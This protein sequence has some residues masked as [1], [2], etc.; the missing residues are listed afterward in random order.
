MELLGRVAATALRHCNEPWYSNPDHLDPV[1]RHLS[2]G[3]ARMVFRPTDQQPAGNHENAADYSCLQSS[4]ERDSEEPSRHQGDRYR[5]D[6]PYSH[7][8]HP[9]GLDSAA[10]ID[11]SPLN[12]VGH[13][14][15]I[16]MQAAPRAAR[17]DY[18][19]WPLACKSPQS[20]L[21]EGVWCTLY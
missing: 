11:T 5:E 2:T 9:H 1:T 20:C 16:W 8:S 17:P 6:V 13:P 15:P 10:A 4:A 21:S 7:S 12:N 3:F 14:D 19:H 18:G